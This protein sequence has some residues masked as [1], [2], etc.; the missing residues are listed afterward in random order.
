MGLDADLTAYYD[1]EARA[2]VRGELDTTRV[3]IRAH[4]SL[5]HF[6][7]FPP[8]QPSGWEYQHAVV[9]TAS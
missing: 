6:E 1:A 4:G 3:D 9:R 7:T 5:E 8:S 2:G